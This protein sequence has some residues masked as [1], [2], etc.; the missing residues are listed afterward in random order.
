MKATIF[1]ISFIFLAAGVMA[2][3]ADARSSR[4]SY[5]K[6]TK[7]RNHVRS[8]APRGVR[9]RQPVRRVRQPARSHYRKPV[10][11]V[12]QPARSHYRKPVRRQYRQPARTHYRKPVRRQ[13][14]QP[15]RYYRQPVRYYGPVSRSVTLTNGQNHAI[16]VAVRT[17]NSSICSANALQGRQFLAPGTSLS[18]ST[19]GSYVCYRQLPTRYSTGSGWYRA[20]V[21]VPFTRL[22]F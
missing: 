13:Y 5:N 14:R 4:R 20:V 15:R 16:R 3:E 17:G 6:A 21:N 10:R 8:R 22:W 18:V 19:L 9:T 7:A 12:R 11:R 1:A 2:S